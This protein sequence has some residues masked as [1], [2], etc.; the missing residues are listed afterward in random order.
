MLVEHCST[1]EDPNPEFVWNSWLRQPLLELG[2]FHHVPPLIQVHPCWTQHRSNFVKNC[3][4]HVLQ[5]AVECSEQVNSVN[6]QHFSF[7]L[8]SRRSRRHPGTRYLARGLNALA[9][10]GNEIEFELVLWSNQKSALGKSSNLGWA[11]CTWR[12]GTVPIWWGVQLHSLQ[13]GLA[14]ETYVRED[15]PYRGTAAYFKG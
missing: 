11:R 3:C 14:A 12:R 15:A 7:A 1:V 8:I 13:K 6:G 4:T 5:G 10:P 9:G 2:L